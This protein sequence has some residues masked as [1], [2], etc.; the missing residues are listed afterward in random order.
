MLCYK[1]IDKNREIDAS[2]HFN[3]K[4]FPFSNFV[5]TFSKNVNIL[6]PKLSNIAANFPLL[7][8]SCFQLK[9]SVEW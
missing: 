3:A 1:K 8:Q 4:I 6:T 2:F 9:L 7:Q 5:R